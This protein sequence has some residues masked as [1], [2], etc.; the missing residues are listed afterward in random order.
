MCTFYNNKNKFNLFKAP[1]FADYCLLLNIFIGR[2]SNQLY[3]GECQN[4]MRS[5]NSK[6]KNI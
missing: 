4:K 5:N 3:S 1:G 2:R 6:K